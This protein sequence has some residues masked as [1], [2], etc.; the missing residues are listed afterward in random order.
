MA[1]SATGTRP[2]RCSASAPKPRPAP[3]TDASPSPMSTSA[4]CASGARSPDAPR[5]PREGTTGC[6]AAFNMPMSSSTTSTRTP[7]RPTASAFA[8]RTSIARTTSSGRGAPT[9]AACE[10]TRLRWSSAVCDGSIRTSARSP[11]PVVTPYAVAPSA[12]RRSITARE[13][14]IRSAAAGS[15]PTALRPRA[16][17]IT[18]SMVRSR[19]VSGSGG[20]GPYTTHRATAAGPHEPPRRP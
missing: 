7:D 8:R 1:S 4:M 15:S 9:P 13:A 14:R 5:L 20:I 3:S 2:A 19:P 17:S 10:R 16:T 11:K 12:T 18:L 6:T